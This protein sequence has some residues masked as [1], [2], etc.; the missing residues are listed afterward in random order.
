MEGRD[1]NMTELLRH[2]D[3]IC[4]SLTV[5]DTEDLVHRTIMVLKGGKAWKK[6]GMAF[7]KDLSPT[8]VNHRT[9]CGWCMTGA[10]YR[11]AVRHPKWKGDWTWGLNPWKYPHLAKSMF[12]ALK[13][14]VPKPAKP[15]DKDIYYQWGTKM[16]CPW[17]EIDESGWEITRGGHEITKKISFEF[18]DAEETTWDDIDKYLHDVLEI[19]MYTHND[20]TV[21][22]MT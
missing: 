13:T 17:W 19:L 14:A 18:N 4:A 7:D 12:R 10:L 16:S 5:K 9:A 1:M 11:E 8:S 20:G 22:A 3:D 2:Y 6:G 15:T 21:D